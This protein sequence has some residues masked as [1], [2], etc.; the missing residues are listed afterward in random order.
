MKHKDQNNNLDFKLPQGTEMTNVAGIDL[1]PKDVGNALQILEFC[2]TF[3]EILGVK[4]GQAESVI[5]DIMGG[6][7]TRRGKY[8]TV[9]QFHIQLLTLLQKDFGEE[10]PSLSA[11]EGKH[12]WLNALKSCLL[13]SECHLKD[14]V[15]CINE[16]NNG[17]NTLD[18]SQKLRLLAFLCDE[19]LGTM[20]VKSWIEDQNFKFIEKQKEEAKAKLA[21]TQGKEK[22]M[23]QKL[24]DEIAKALL[25][26]NG[27]PLTMLE[28]QSIVSKIKAEASKAHADMVETMG[29]VP[30]RKQR[31]D[32]MRTE[33]VL[34]DAKG[35]ICWRLKG[36]N[37]SQMVLQVC[38]PEDPVTCNEKWFSFNAE[39]EKLIEKHLH[40][41][42]VK[43]TKRNKDGA[44]HEMEAVDS[45]S[46]L[47]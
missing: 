6:R 1:S 10:T 32:A 13:E 4:K 40:L 36:Y 21:A 26:N 7:G 15:K 5:R 9:V 34:V 45:H 28:H 46:K 35:N 39:E 8:S 2:A 22:M 27:A 31:S 3:G 23:K 44:V 11:S 42:R 18:C 29:L 38:G 14:F 16:G 20:E 30:R 33:P 12:C 43:R 24:Q 47:S 25:T 37:N 17:Y 19:T 41:F